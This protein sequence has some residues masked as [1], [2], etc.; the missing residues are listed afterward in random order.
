MNARDLAKLLKP[1]GVSA[2]SVKIAGTV[3]R[4]YRR[5]DLH[6]SW[7]RYLAPAHVESATSATTA[8]AQVEDGSQVAG[9]TRDPLPGTA[10]STSD[11]LPAT[12]SEPLTCEVAQ[13]AEVADMTCR[14]CG[15][16]LD[17]VLIDAGL[18]DHGETDALLRNESA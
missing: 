2:C 8:T 3:K 5:E 1:Y 7:T 14:V 15:E 17:Q 4:G 10:G 6:D 18:T 12:S 9:S 13:V 16:L 11:V